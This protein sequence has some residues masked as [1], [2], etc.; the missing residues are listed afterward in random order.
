MHEE[1]ATIIAEVSGT[2]YGVDEYWRAAEAST[3]LKIVVFDAIIRSKLLYAL[4]T[5][6][7]EWS[8]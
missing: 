7:L 8:Y 2:L 4:E 3:K 1:V 5:F 6:Y